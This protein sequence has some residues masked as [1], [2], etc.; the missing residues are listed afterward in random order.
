MRPN[1]ASRWVLY[2]VAI[3]LA[4]VS[5]IIGIFDIGGVHSN[6]RDFSLDIYTKTKPFKGDLDLGKKM[7]LV[8]IDETTLARFGQWPWPRHYMAV[9]VQNIGLAE[10]RVIGLDILMSEDD[11]FNAAAIETLGGLE[12]GAL[13]TSL[14]DGDAQ[15]GEMLSYTPSVLA[16]ALSDQNSANPVYS[17]GS[18]SVIGSASLP[19]LESTHLLSP[20]P[21]VAQSPG[22]GFVSFASTRD[23]VV[24][25]M[26]MVARYN[27]QT[28]PSLSLEMLRVAQGTNGHVLKQASDTGSVTNQIR[29][30]GLILELDE[31]GRMPVY[32]GYSD[33]FT[34]VSAIDVLE[35][36]GLERLR[37][38]F[39]VIGSSAS[40]LKDIHA[41]NLEAALPG[42]MIHLHVIHQI[43]SGLTLQS[44]YLYDLAEIITAFFIAII[45]GILAINLPIIAAIGA[46]VLITGGVIYG[47]FILFTDFYY[48]TNA[49]FSTSMVLL[50]GSLVLIAQA[51]SDEMARRNLRGAFGQYLA[52]EMV[53]QIEVSRTSPELGGTTSDISVMFMDVRG[54]TALSERLAD[55][56]HE[57][58][59]IINLILDEATNVIM[60]HGGTLDKYI[61]DA[62][63]AFWNAPLPQYDHH[64]RAVDAAIALQAHV[65]VINQRLEQMMGDAW[66][67]GPIAIGV[68]VASGKAVVGNFGSKKRLS[69]SV[70]GD[71]VNLAARLEPFS[72]Q[73][74]LPLAFSETIALASQHPDL[75]KLNDISISGRG[76]TEAVYSYLPLPETTRTQHD[77]MLAELLNDNLSGVTRSLTVLEKATDYPE[78]LITY[79]SEQQAAGK[80]D[81][82]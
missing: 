81:Q 3:V 60:D 37:N 25:H 21:K 78:S 65:P 66:S 30:G 54:F 33:R 2:A 9:M 26:P 82:V 57:L 64:R 32:H 39:V 48:L 11:R 42:A 77:S 71:V 5:A 16:F 61:G 70:V 50:C 28:L 17:P 13:A 49:V 67:G 46:I 43:L 63:M 20:V 76:A 72:K 73:T 31:F 29:S 53:K 58:T 62:V 56:P 7:V 59:Q 80:S 10:P 18:V 24:R 34:T 36:V 35:G 75:I 47:E 55:K 68:G 15:L 52:P 14:P 44:S 8:D 27:G 12:Q 79:Y 23:A 40:G 69:Y 6:T 41:T 45:V 22:A 19:V 4:T 1:L 51:I 74:G 38:A